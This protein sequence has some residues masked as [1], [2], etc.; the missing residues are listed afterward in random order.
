MPP[1]AESQ[2]F[3]TVRQVEAPVQGEIPPAAVNSESCRRRG[4]KAPPA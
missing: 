3:D 4:L 1:A 2:A